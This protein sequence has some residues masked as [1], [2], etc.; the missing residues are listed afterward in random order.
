M[1][2]S[3]CGPSSTP[4]TVHGTSG[5]DNVHISKAPGLAGALGFFEVDVNG[6]KQ[7]MTKD[8]LEHTDFKLGAGNDTLV[9][10]SNVNA[11]ITAHGGSGNDVMI[12]GNGN[13][14]FDGGA[15]NDI[16]AGRGGN[17]CLNG[18]NGND[19][20]LGGNGND[21]LRG[22][23]GND[24]LGGGNGNDVLLGG[25]GR[26]NLQGGN[27]SD[28]LDGGAGKDHNNGGPGLDFVRFDLRDYL[29]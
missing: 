18:G 1:C 17:D 5:D 8:Q 27:G 11:N 6:H 20:L 14:H 2:I 19:V 26:D 15:G 24:Y 7:L 13:D 28:Y 9:V 22:G 21:V 23:R 4:N 3:P 10:D 16:L 12:G 25:A 29:P